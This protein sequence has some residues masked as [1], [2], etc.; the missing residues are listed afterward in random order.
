MN[1]ERMDTEPSAGKNCG[2]WLPWETY[3]EYQTKYCYDSVK[4][5][6]C[7]FICHLHTDKKINNVIIKKIEGEKLIQTLIM[8][9]YL[10]LMR[11]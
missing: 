3:K 8:P 10:V 1:F 6:K 9:S 4:K 11:F 7:S 2:F 5:S